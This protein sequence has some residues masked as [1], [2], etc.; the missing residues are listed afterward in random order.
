MKKI[1]NLPLPRGV[2]RTG[3]DSFYGRCGKCKCG[4]KDLFIMR[5]KYVCHDC[6]CPDYDAHTLA[7]MYRRASHARWD[8]V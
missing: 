5:G 2:H 7:Y 6:L 3:R 4:G 8:V 1:K